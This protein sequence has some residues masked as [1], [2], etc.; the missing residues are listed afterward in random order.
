ML[1]VSH[2]M[3]H[4][5]IKAISCNSILKNLSLFAKSDMHVWQDKTSTNI[6]KSKMYANLGLGPFQL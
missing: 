5:P 6:I 3:N 4:P 2:L 1:F